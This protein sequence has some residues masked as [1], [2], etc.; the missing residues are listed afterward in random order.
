MIIYFDCESNLIRASQGWLSSDEAAAPGAGESTFI[1]ADSQ[2]GPGS[3]I[4]AQPGLGFDIAAWSSWQ[5][6]SFVAGFKRLFRAYQEAVLP[7][8]T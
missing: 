7:L 4:K 5:C 2:V 1:M 8:M 6:D 3:R